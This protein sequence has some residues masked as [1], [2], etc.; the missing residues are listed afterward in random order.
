MRT[1]LVEKTVEQFHEIVHELM[2][3]SDIS[4]DTAYTLAVKIQENLLRAEYNEFYGAAHVVDTLQP[5]PSALE[6]IAME[7]ERFNN[8]N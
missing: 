8:N 5:C 3:S 4:I 7:I 2:E 1:R 6:K